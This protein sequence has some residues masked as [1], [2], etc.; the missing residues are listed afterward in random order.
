MNPEVG[1]DF[2]EPDL[3]KRVRSALAAARRVEERR[4]FGGIT[5][6]VRGKMCVS[7]GKGRLMCRID[8]T[9]HDT[10]LRRPGCRTVTMKWRQYRGYVYVQAEAVRTKSAL[11][12]WVG[13]ALDYNSKVKP[14]TRKKTA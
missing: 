2:I 6:M 1:P 9:I 14:S 8:P 10:V 12:Y 7:A 3:A 4:M 13:L 5:F 11:D